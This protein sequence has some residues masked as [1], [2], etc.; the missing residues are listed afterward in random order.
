MGLA[1]P[2]HGPA[3][4]AVVLDEDDGSS[5]GGVSSQVVLEPGDITGLALVG[6]RRAAMHLDQVQS[7]P[8]PGVISAGRIETRHSHG[9][10]ALVAALDVV[11]HLRAVPVR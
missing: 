3:V 10:P 5:V 11:P 1:P 9:G 7:T 2:T 4:E 6:V 8:V